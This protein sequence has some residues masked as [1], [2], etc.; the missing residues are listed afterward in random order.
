LKLTPKDLLSFRVIDR[1]VT[2]P[3]GGA[4]RDPAAAAAMLKADLLTSLG[5]LGRWSQDS[6][7][8]QRHQKFLSL[9]VFHEE[10]ARR[11]SLLQ[12]LRDFF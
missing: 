7:L 3:A 10:E 8:A 5:V 1:I 2:E 12:R 4:H 6:L 11:R 9:G